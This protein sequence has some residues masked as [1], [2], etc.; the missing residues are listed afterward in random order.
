MPAPPA[1][2][3]FG[4]PQGGT[5]AAG[6]GAPPAVSQP[7]PGAPE[8]PYP[9]APVDA[10]TGHTLWSKNL[11]GGSSE[12]H[13][14]VTV[15]N[16]VV[17]VAIGR[18]CAGFSINGTEKWPLTSRGHERTD[19]TAYSPDHLVWS[20]ER[21]GTKPKRLLS[22]Q[23]LQYGS[24][25]SKTTGDPRV[26]SA[27]LADRPLTVLMASDANKIAPELSVRTVDKDL[28]PDHTFTIE[29]ELKDLDL[30]PRTTFVDE[31]EQALVAAYGNVGGT[32]AVDLKP[33]KLLWK[34]QGTPVAEGDGEVVAVASAPP[35]GGGQDPV[36]V[37]LHVRDGKQ[38]VK[39][40]LCDPKHS[41]G[42]PHL[43]S[44]T[45]SENEQTLYL[46]GERLCG[47]RPSL[48][49]FKLNR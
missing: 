16:K 21:P 4:K 23:D 12:D 10:D 5:A 49:A 18:T 33:G 42:A 40:I 46:E 6:Q 9:G 39:G 15:N 43:M 2:P 45:W 37:S 35:T 29:G 1:G 32:A 24:L 31:G 44:F 3:G 34:K 8:G 28:K 47:D 25:N 27:V 7:G 26:A 30:H 11:K 38:T 36:L 14:Q 48:R 22:V 41:L 17:S 19:G 20:S 13:P